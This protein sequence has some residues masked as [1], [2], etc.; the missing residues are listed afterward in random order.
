ML[1]WSGKLSSAGRSLWSCSNR[2]FRGELPSRLLPEFILSNLSW[3]Q[4]N[5]DRSYDLTVLWSYEETKHWKDDSDSSIECMQLIAEYISLI[6]LSLIS[7]P[8]NI[9][10]LNIH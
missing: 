6:K 7:C 5:D 2:T 3:K 4:Y 9:D 10:Q 8:E 1:T